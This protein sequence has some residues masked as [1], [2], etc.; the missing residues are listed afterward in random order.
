M[1]ML[2]DGHDIEGIRRRGEAFVPIHWTDQQS[3]GGRT[4]LLPRAKVDPHSG[5]PG[6]KST[7]VRVEKVATEW[8]GFLLSAEAPAKTDLAYATRVK[9]AG[10]WLVEFAWSPPAVLAG[11]FAIVASSDCRYLG[12][13]T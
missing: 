1:V 11:G 8:R 10:G 5:Q 3:S 2:H 9:V 12:A 7:P 4:G 13:L 6:F